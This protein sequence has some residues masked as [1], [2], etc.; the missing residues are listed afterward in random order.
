MVD[1]NRR[2]VLASG[3]ALAADAA[4]SANSRA[5][6]DFAP[7][8]SA[9]R[10]LAYSLS[11]SMPAA[12]NAVS[13]AASIRP[14]RFVIEGG[15]ND[16]ITMPRTAY[17]VVYPDGAIMLDSGLDE[18]THRSFSPDKPE[19]FYS[20]EF[21]KL[22]AALDSAKRI[23]LTHFHADHVGGVVTAP[24]FRELAAKTLATPHTLQIMME[25]PH[26]PNLKL[27]TADA[28]HFV[29]LDYDAMVAIAPGLVLFKAPGHSPD[30]QMAFIKL[31]D[32][33]EFL[34]S[35]DAAWIKDNIA[36][37]KGKAAPWVNE[38]VEQVN[39]Q[40]AWLHAFELAHPDIPVLVTH[41]Q[42]QFDTLRGNGTIGALEV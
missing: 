7:D 32:G 15:N 8:L 11:G 36:Q 16:P 19:P 13:V 6:E 41:D 18:A 30:M 12:L 29:M 24:N 37:V 20:D 21:G 27:S 22:R 25:A 5:S 3:V 1:V 17:Q 38:N 14:R 34:H 2:M 26:R 23:V 35:I 31:R 10:R 9:L 40:L 39:A 4:W 28:A 33:R 42:T